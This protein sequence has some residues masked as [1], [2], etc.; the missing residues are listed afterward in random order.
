MQL[1]RIEDSI[2]HYNILHKNLVSLSL[3]LDNFPSN[4]IKIYHE[5]LKFPDEIMRRDI[6]DELQHPEQITL[7]TPPSIP[8]CASCA[9]L[10]VSKRKFFVCLLLFI[11]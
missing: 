5:I 4:N 1:G 10:K 11:V 7:P 8:P 2:K 9:E 6:M 3:A